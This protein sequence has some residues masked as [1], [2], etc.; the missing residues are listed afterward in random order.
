[1]SKL[2]IRFT[3]VTPVGDVYVLMVVDKNKDT[4]FLVSKRPMSM[5]SFYKRVNTII[6][7]MEVMVDPTWFGHKTYRP[8]M[9]TGQRGSV[10]EPFTRRTFK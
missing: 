2:G 10:V 3:R 5:Y 8:T 9:V 1:M 7:S 6:E 4:L